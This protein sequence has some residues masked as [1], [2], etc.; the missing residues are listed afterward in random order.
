M[1]STLPVPCPK[2]PSR[3]LNGQLQQGFSINHITENLP[4]VFNAINRFE[5]IIMSPED[6]LNFAINS[7]AIRFPEYIDTKTNEVRSDIIQK[8]VNVE[9][10]LVAEREEDKGDNLWL[11]FNRVQG[12]II[13]GGFQRMGITDQSKSVRPLT[14]IRM[15][16]LVNKGLWKL[17]DDYSQG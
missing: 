7:L 12:H 11:T 1:A 6:Q 13:N 17:M 5:G 2:I 3:L 4:E 10:L 16:I 15:N 14:N 8:K 9:D